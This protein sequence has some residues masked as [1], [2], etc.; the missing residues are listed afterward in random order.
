MLK[1]TWN[2]RL[3]VSRI[4][5]EYSWQALFHGYAKTIAGWVWN[6]SHMRE[7]CV[8]YY[9][10]LTVTLPRLY[11]SNRSLTIKSCGVDLVLCNEVWMIWIPRNIQ[12]K[13]ITLQNVLYTTMLHTPTTAVQGLKNI[14]NLRIVVLRF[15]LNFDKQFVTKTGWQLLAEGRMLE[16]ELCHKVPRLPLL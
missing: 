16:K 4:S 3:V 13:D 7:L 10:Y 1:L 14:A 12:A 15:T 8:A 2:Y 9:F 5:L 6:S 11:F